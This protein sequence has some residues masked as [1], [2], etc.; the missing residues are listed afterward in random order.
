MKYKI[1][2]RERT[3]FLDKRGRGTDGY[4]IFFEMGDGTMDY[5]EIEKAQYNI[6]NVNAAIEAS[7]A[8]HEEVIGI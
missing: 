1:E 6:V 5:V 7:V 4:R 2:K 3:N 8:L